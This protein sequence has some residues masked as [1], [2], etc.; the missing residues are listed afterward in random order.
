MTR[1]VRPEHET[2]AA[3]DAAMPVTFDDLFGWVHP[4]AGRRGVLLCGACGFEQMAAHRPWRALADRLAAA[5]CPTL[6]FDYPGEGNSGDPGEVRVS[7]NVAAIRRAMRF[8][9][10][11]T[12]VTEI[13]LVG[14]RLGANLALLAAQEE[15]VDRLVLLAPAATGRAYLREMRLRARTVGGV[16]E[17]AAPKAD[18]DGLSVGGFRM[19]AAFLTDV[20]ALDAGAITRAPAPRTLLLAPETRTLAGRLTALGSAVETG[21]LPGLPL[22]VGDPIFAEVPEADFNR[23]TAFA[24]DGVTIAGPA[25]PLD[26]GPAHLVG[27][28]WSEAPARFQPDLFGISCTPRRQD[29]GAPTV[30]FVSTG[31]TV[32]SGWGRQTT[33]L[34]RRLAVDGIPSFRFDLAGIGDSGGRSDGRRPPYAPDGFADVG[35]ALDHLAEVRGPIVLMGNCSGA[36]AAFQALCRDARVDGA[37]LINPYCF[38][39]DPDQDVDAVIRQTFG[40]TGTYAALLKRGATWRRLLR[41]EIHVRAIGATLAKRGLDAAVR[42]LRRLVNPISPGGSVARRV[43]RLRRRG[44]EIRLVYSAGDPGLAALHRYLGR[45]PGR[46]DRHLGAPVAIVPEVDHNF[47]SATAQAL[48]GHHLRDLLTAVQEARATR[49]EAHKPVETDS[50]ATV[51]AS[52]A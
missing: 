21:P 49:T 38:D 52:L 31:M 29:P 51:L 4:A 44:A 39:W 27:P 48:L 3:P 22:L 35:R 36:H 42:R 37:L 16:A 6:R 9:R 7:A 19:D 8:L 23:I 13:V 30:V 15:S 50:R 47:S 40:S 26:L 18:P 12:G 41:G 46:A 17:G 34:A 33:T 24:T 45:A 25:I 10:E 11:T 20:G 5:G 1:E 28:G 2:H 32:H 43:A 14:L